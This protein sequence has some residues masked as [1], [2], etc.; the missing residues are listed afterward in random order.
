MYVNMYISEPAIKIIKKRRIKPHKLAGYY[1][2]I[3]VLQQAS[4]QTKYR[5]ILG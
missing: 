1:Y 5:W 4:W 3:W 2:I